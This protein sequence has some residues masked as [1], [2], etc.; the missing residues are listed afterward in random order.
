M[1]IYVG[2][3]V[4]IDVGFPSFC[5]SYVLPVDLVRCTS[6]KSYYGTQK[7]LAGAG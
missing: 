2:Y 1:V 6:N 5:L 4:M 7:L 3:W